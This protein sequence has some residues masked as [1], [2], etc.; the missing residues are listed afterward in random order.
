MMKIIPPG[1]AVV[2]RI[3]EIIFNAKFEKKN[4]SVLLTVTGAMLQLDPRRRPSVNHIVAQ[5]QEIGAARSVNLKGP[6]LIL[7]RKGNG[8]NVP[9]PPQTASPIRRPAESAAGKC[10][11][12]QACIPGKIFCLV[13][14]L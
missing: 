6:L 8:I 12:Y 10:C 14:V 9:T 5:L 3:K 4:I 1:R 7:E 2:L 13:F 11:K